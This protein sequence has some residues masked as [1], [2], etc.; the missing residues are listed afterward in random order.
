MSNVYLDHKNQ[1]TSEKSQ[2]KYTNEITTNQN[3]NSRKNNLFSRKRQFKPLKLT[4][5]EIIKNAICRTKRNKSHILFS[6]AETKIMYYMD[7]LTYVRLL[8]EIELLKQVL[9]NDQKRFLFEFLSK[10][11]LDDKYAKLD[12]NYY[13]KKSE[14]ALIIDFKEIE[15]LYKCYNKVK[16]DNRKVSDSNSN[17]HRL[18]NMINEEIDLLRTQ[19]I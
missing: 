18:I 7:V 11:L 1:S 8:R 14:R 17:S 6:L 10:P 13:T 3:I 19:N 12:E 15:G 4:C 9:F 5:F 2:Q 16:S